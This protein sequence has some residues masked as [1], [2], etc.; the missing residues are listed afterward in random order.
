[1][2]DSKN[3]RRGQPS[4]RNVKRRKRKR[5]R[6]NTGILMGVLAVVVII[7]GFK[8]LSATNHRSVYGKLKHSGYAGSQEQFLASLV[9]EE[10]EDTTETAYSLAVENGYKGTK[11]D[12]YEVLTGVLT[13]NIE[14]EGTPYG[15]ACKNG[16]AGS[17]EEWL[18][19]LV[20]KPEK[21]GLSKNKK[22][23]TEYEL[24]CTYGYTGT[25]IEWLVALTNDKVF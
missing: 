7:A 12:W 6:I 21:L 16:Y 20:D 17:L 9:G 10:T 3:T 22:Q 2:K 1:M 15:F 19:T 4:R 25:F 18:E 23:Q 14:I 13:E 11:N 8:I 5:R 24:A